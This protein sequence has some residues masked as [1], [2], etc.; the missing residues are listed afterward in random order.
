MGCRRQGPAGASRGP[1]PILW[2]PGQ[3]ALSSEPPGRPQG[4]AEAR[5]PQQPGGDG[6]VL[7]VC[8]LG[9]QSGEPWS[10]ALTT[11]VAS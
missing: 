3:H 4:R 11:L 6:P 2:R 8:V 5:A 10:F 7:Q 9:S 1:A